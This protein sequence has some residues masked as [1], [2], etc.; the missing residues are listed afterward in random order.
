MHHLMTQ[1]STRGPSGKIQNLWSRSG[2][3]EYSSILQLTTGLS[4]EVGHHPTKGSEATSSNEE[5]E[6]LTAAAGVRPKC[7][8]CGLLEELVEV[9]GPPSK[10]ISLS[11]HTDLSPLGGRPCMCCI[12]GVFGTPPRLETGLSWAPKQTF[13]LPGGR[14]ITDWAVRIHSRS[15]YP[16][17]PLQGH[18][19]PGKGSSCFPVRKKGPPPSL[20]RKK[21][22]C[23]VTLEEPESF[24][25]LTV[26]HC[27]CLR[28]GT[29]QTWN[30]LGPSDILYR[31]ADQHHNSLMLRN[32]M[33]LS[34]DLIKAFLEM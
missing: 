14:G 33:A 29:L 2:A 18:A 34:F 32:L 5:T 27:K 3:L 15:V 12:S 25:E 16:Q 1:H 4:I 13:V 22:F 24:M 31:N 6:E 20:S 26:P 28:L 11:C 30:K 8:H 23:P 21:W 19:W 9:A 17:H 7:W 10:T